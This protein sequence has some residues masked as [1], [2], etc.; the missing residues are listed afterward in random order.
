MV[1]L[2]D[3]CKAD[4]WTSDFKEVS[5]AIAN[6]PLLSKGIDI[7]SPIQPNDLEDPV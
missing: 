6:D 7:V 5:E 1:P 4:G 2:C 3:A